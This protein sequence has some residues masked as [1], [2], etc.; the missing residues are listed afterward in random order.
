MTE[1]SSPSK[2]QISPDWLVQG[3]LTKIGDTFDRLTGRGWK[4]SSSLAT[5]ELI[6]KLKKLVDSEVRESNGNRRFIP[7]NIKLKMQWD[8]F[9]TDSED[10]LKKLETELLTALVD[11]INDKRYYT[12]SPITLEVK[13]DYFTSGV[14]LFAGFEKSDE[15]ERETAIDVSMPGFKDDLSVRATLSDSVLDRERVIVRFELLGKTYQKELVFEDGKRLSVGRTKENDLAVDDTSVSKMHASLMMN[16]ERHLV[17]ADTGSTNG[18][19]VD[20]ERISYGKAVTFLADQKL[21][22]GTVELAFE[23]L[24]KPIMPEAEPAPTE[25]F[26]V[27]EFEF[28]SKVDKRDLTEQIV[29]AETVAGVQ[30]PEIAVLKAASLDSPK[31]TELSININLQDDEKAVSK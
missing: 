17:V 1:K 14:K 13:P 21:R 16:A 25:A 30:V 22:I 10:T 28:T 27:G 8:K 19:F 7:H 5:S 11:H 3:I 2:K 6:E 31:A 12:Y 20:G 18:T 29:P 23:V 9:S 15:E 24:E 26:K 4:P